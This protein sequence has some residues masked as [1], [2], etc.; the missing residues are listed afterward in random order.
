[1][2]LVQGRT[3]PTFFRTVFDIVMNQK[4]VMKKL[5]HGSGR[6]HLFQTTAKR[7]T[8]RDADPRAQAFCAP[9]DKL[10]HQTVGLLIGG[11]P[12]ANNS[13]DFD[14]HRCAAGFEIVPCEKIHGAKSYTKHRDTEYRR[15]CYRFSIR[16]GGDGKRRIAAGAKMSRPLGWWIG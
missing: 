16:V 4:R 15:Y 7:A 8:N 13:I 6:R 10:A 9:R 5:H 2:T 14:K 11:R 1:M 12:L 3:T